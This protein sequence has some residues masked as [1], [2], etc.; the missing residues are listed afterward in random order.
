MRHLA[1]IIISLP[2]T[3]ALA[4]NPAHLEQFQYTKRCEGCD[5]NTLS[6]FADLLGT[7]DY[8]DAVLTGTYV[9]GS[10]IEHL[11]LQRLS[12]R[13]MTGLGFMLH[14][15]DLTDADFSYSDFPYA[16]VTGF[17]RGDRVSFK[18]STLDHSHFS[19]T[20]FEAPNLSGAAMRYASLYRISWP[21][22]NL[23]ETLLSNADLTYANLRGANLEKAILT[24]ALVNHA[25]FSEANLL[26]ATITMEQLK[27]AKSICHAVL[28]DGSI[29]E[30]VGANTG[31]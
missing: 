30:C 22:A 2:F 23:S 1:S 31:T 16:K 3:L 4:H 14:D 26:G 27:K 9:Y 10:S 20:T 24:N 13:E 7:H 18:G 29:G 11:D 5:L 21:N 17:N 19:Y 28:P 12:A 15:N 25:D 6:I 8:A